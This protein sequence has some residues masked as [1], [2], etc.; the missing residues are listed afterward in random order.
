M[1]SPTALKTGKGERHS[2]SNAEK[3]DEQAQSTPSSEKKNS[4]TLLPSGR[5]VFDLDKI[6]LPR[7]LV[8]FT[9]TEIREAIT[10]ARTAATLA[11][12][13][14]KQLDEHYAQRF[15]RLCPLEPIHRFQNHC[16]SIDRLAQWAEDYYRE[17]QTIAPT[18]KLPEFMFTFFVAEDAYLEYVVEHEEMKTEY[19][20]GRYLDWRFKAQEL[21]DKL[22]LS[23]ISIVEKRQC[24]T[25]W[26]GFMNEMRKWETRL[27]ELKLPTWGR[28]IDELAHTIENV[29][30]LKDEWGF[31]LQVRKEPW[32]L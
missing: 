1:S 20:T 3:G 5:Y 21:V 16:S 12:R 19:L 8:I 24:L 32:V 29:V 6:R 28:M 11:F 31:A 15:Y 17:D 30:D 10:A 7:H 26:N 4:R 27:D 13:E 22:Y 25:W 2:T 18:P 14:L 23:G 9:T